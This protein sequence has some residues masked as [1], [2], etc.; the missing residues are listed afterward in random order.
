ML[1]NEVVFHRSCCPTGPLQIYRY[2]R[3]TSWI[4]E[5]RW[6]TPALLVG[7][8]ATRR[9]SERGSPCCPQRQ[10]WDPISRRALRQERESPCQGQASRQNIRRGRH[11][12]LLLHYLTQHGPAGIL[13]GICL[14]LQGASAKVTTEDGGGGERHL[15]LKSGLLLW[16]SKLCSRFSR[17]LRRKCDTNVAFCAAGN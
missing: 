9:Q 10:A 7:R 16:A 15:C 8:S 13:L 5:S 17:D 3:V 6:P 14:T 4:R 2:H 11:K 1:A 12:S